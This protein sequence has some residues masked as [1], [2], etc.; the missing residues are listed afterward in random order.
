MPTTSRLARFR[1][2]SASLP[3]SGPTTSGQRRSLLPVWDAPRTLA[4]HDRVR[5]APSP[6]LARG[7]AG[8]MAG[9]PNCLA[10]SGRLPIAC[11][12]PCYAQSE[13]Y[14][15]APSSC[16]N[17][18]SA[19]HSCSFYLPLSIPR[20][21]LPSGRYPRAFELLACIAPPRPGNCKLVYF[22]RPSRASCAAALPRRAE[23][24]SLLPRK[25]V[26]VVRKVVSFP[27]E[28]MLRAL[29]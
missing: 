25:G 29:E 19:L 6:R 22:F 23:P 1:L 27:F 16:F 11:R 13:S 26:V 7:R 28:G 3:A 4:S 5:T 2:F 12:G 20:L 21:S 14:R 8:P 10:L 9:G 18:A 17:R 15:P 24:T